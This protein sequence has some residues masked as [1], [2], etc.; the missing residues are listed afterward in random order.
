MDFSESSTCRRKGRGFDPWPSETAQAWGHLA[1]ASQL[2]SLSSRAQGPQPL[3]LLCPG[4]FA[5]Q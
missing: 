3:K 5:L 4:A 2:L 1:H